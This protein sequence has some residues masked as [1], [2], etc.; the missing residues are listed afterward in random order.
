M[1]TVNAVNFNFLTDL[2]P[3]I[4]QKKVQFGF[5][6]KVSYGAERATVLG[7]NEPPL[8]MPT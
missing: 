8:R 7:R 2:Y 6:L 3:I 1:I 4:K 5:Y